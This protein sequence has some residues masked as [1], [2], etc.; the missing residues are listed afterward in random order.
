MSLFAG[1]EEIVTENQPLADFTWFKIGG[2]ARY[3]VKP[4][5]E[6]DLKTALRRCREN[7]LPWRILGHGANLLVDDK[8]V[9]GAVIK[10]DESGFGK[11]EI[12]EER[13]VRIGGAVSLAGMVLQ[14]V[15]KGL[16]G[17]ETLVG[18]PGSV[19]GAVKMNA[20]GRFGDIGTFITKIT[21]VDSSGG[22]FSR[23]KPELNFEYRR[24]NIYDQIV[25]EAELEF[26]P[27]DPQRLMTKMREVWI[28]K[29][30]AQPLSSR[31]AG[32]VFKNPSPDKPAGA[33][34]DKAGLKGLT[35]GGAKISEQHANFIVVEPGVRFMDIVS[36][37]DRMKTAVFEKFGI[38][39]ELEIDVWED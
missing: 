1:L 36:I 31:S 14:C 13:I 16:S 35:V 6:D 10:L 37:I 28:L 4:R 11:M 15:R 3:F 26:V 38:D 5:S 7:N 20:G 25:T 39:L 18:I 33:L 22:S 8:G 30:T 34:I 32:C 2:P 9:E 27:D 23:E 19:G 21:V 24:A 12:V 17:A 29:K